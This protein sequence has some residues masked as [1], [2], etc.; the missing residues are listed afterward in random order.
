MH[1]LPSAMASDLMRYR[2]MQLRQVAPP[3]Q[4]PTTHSAPGLKVAAPFA[5]LRSWAG[6]NLIQIG[7]RLAVSPR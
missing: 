1:P 5:K 6:W 2:T 3:R 7:L 4:P